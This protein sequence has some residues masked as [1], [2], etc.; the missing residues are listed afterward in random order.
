MGEWKADKRNGSGT[1]SIFSPTYYKGITTLADG[2]KFE[3]EWDNGERNGWNVMEW[4]NGFHFQG[5]FIRG[6]P[7]GYIL[8]IVFDVI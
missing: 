6:L 3:G 1:G 4:A 2:S 7:E 8:E 5:N